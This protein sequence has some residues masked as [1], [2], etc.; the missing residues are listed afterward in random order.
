MRFTWTLQVVALLALALAGCGRGDAPQVS[1]PTAGVAVNELREPAELHY[2]GLAACVECHAAET[3]AWRGSHHDLAMAPADER[4]VLGDF[5]DTAF[6]HGDVESRFYR[7]DGRFFV[8]TDGPD[9]E[10]AEFELKFTFG[11]DPLQQYLVEFSDG[12]LQALGIAWDTR[13]PE[14]GGQRWFHVY[15]DEIIPAGD[16]L[17]WTM[18]A[19]NWNYMC[20][21]CH[22]TGYEKNYAAGSDTFASTWS[23]VDVACEACHGPG[24]VHVARAR[25][26]RLA[27]GHGFPLSFA[28]PGR[29]RLFLEGATTVSIVGADPAA[30]QVESC[31][32]CH[33]RR[34]PLAA[35]YRH[36]APLLDTYLPALLSESLYFADG[37]MLDEVFEYGSFRQSKM[38]QAGVVCSDC[39]EPH[40]LQLRA[41]GD[42]VCAQCHLPGHYASSAHSHHE[43]GPEAPGC[44]DCHM[45]ARNY[46]V[47]DPRRDHSFRVPRPDLSVELGVTNACASCHADRPD[48]WSAVAVRGWLGRDASGL[49]NYARAFAAARAGRIAAADPLR[50]VA[51]DSEQPAIVRATALELLQGYP[52]P[53]T[54]ELAARSLEDPDP[55]VRG[56]ALG[57]LGAVPMEQRSELVGDLWGD[58]V[59]A[60]RIEA[61]RMLAGLDPRG[62]D[63]AARDLF[64]AALDDYI[65]AQNASLDR[66]AARLNLG[67]LYSQGGDATLAQQQYRA[68][69]ALDPSF[70]PA[71]VN[72][73]DLLFRLQ[74][75]LGAGEVLAK[76]LAVVPDG[77]L[78]NHAMGLHQIRSAD[79]VA[80]LASLARAAE[81][82]PQ[83]A[84][85]S[86]VYAVALTNQGRSDE[87]LEVLER[88]HEIRE[89][90]QDVLH[91]LVGIHLQSGD[92]GA[93]R[94]YLRKL[95][96]LRPWDAQ[97]EELLRRLGNDS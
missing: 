1:Q 63:G 26:K 80:A 38:Y 28:Q 50:R 89:A 68:A 13:P 4:T 72:L 90:D 79:P 41:D 34:A 78:L 5:N 3:A 12:R 93:A 32:R 60:V 8:H 71:Y 76:G 62:L 83:N 81:L 84:R 52:A 56:A 31:G 2:V 35:N 85:L 59:L 19:Q 16:E 73:A 22:S 67:N 48:E 24:S 49:Q 64:A 37:Q 53:E 87:A 66:P 57:L 61:A 75:E 11:W 65:A 58:P 33:A 39:H 46:M 18:P 88:A 54:L 55:A 45:P 25:E 29:Q 20:A 92:I 30:M 21:D 17:H 74:D 91:A 94:N 7:R 27:E 96:Q 42:A 6:E 77:A 40:S 10:L 86:Y 69:L 14:A 36:G 9:G 51:A 44:I 43:P 15:G 97:V 47:V 70:E 82:A 23:D 95:Q